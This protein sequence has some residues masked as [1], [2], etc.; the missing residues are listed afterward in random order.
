MVAPRKTPIRPTWAEIN[1]DNL[2]HNYRQLK[3]L[4]GDTKMMGVVKADAYG[5]GAVEIAK[6][7][8]SLEVD[9]LGVA[10]LDEAVQLREADICTPILILGYTPPDHIACCL[11]HGITPTVYTPEVAQ[12]CSDYAQKHNC[13]VKIHIKIDTGMGRIGVTP[14][15]AVD[16]IRE[17]R[18]YPGVEIEGLFT[19]FSSADEEDKSYTHHQL[20]SFTTILETLESNGI[21]IPLKHAAN[22][23]ATISVPESYFDMV[24]VGLSLYGLYPAP[25]MHDLVSLRPVLSVKSRVSFLK[26]VPGG[27]AISYG[28]KY[29]TDKESIIGTLPIGYADGFT[30]LF[31]NRGEVL[32]RGTRVPVIGS[33]CMDQ[34]MFLGDRAPQLQME[35]EVV[36][37]GQQGDECITVEE[38]AK[39]MGTINY[40]IVT[41]VDQRVPRLFWKQGEW[42]GERTLTWSRSLE[43]RQE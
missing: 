21:H 15:R 26:M 36:I 20:A 19:H 43:Q 23:P 10:T 37:I 25:Y 41:M 33:V 42:V 5:H 40:E 13:R 11:D 39:K 1:L 9:Y 34:A 16:F 32:V 24:R 2:Q 27:S 14:D 31:T 30:R 12:A 4:V 6:E 7:L 35:D 38:L 28:R 29:I 18:R 22:S 8:V 3:N 17:V